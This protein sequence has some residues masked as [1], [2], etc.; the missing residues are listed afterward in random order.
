[1]SR[2]LV[3]EGVD[4]SGKSL[5]AR[6]LVTALQRA[7]HPVRHLR[8][9]G[10]TPVGEALRALLL[11]PET[12][13]LSPLCEMLLFSAA[14]AE[15]VDRA[16]RPELA[17]GIVVVAERSYLSTLVYQALAP[18]QD[19]APLALVQQVTSAVLGDRRPDRIFV[20]DLPADVARARR[21]NRAADRFE[22]R[23]G[24][25]LERV[26]AAFHDSARLDPRVELV[27]ARGT[28]EAVHQRILGSAGACLAERHG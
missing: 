6:L 27:D 19:A 22:A 17:A 26:C 2:W 16:V 28:I 5:Q 23:D 21:R 15:F 18:L 9:P 13:P 1:V 24:D 10:S 12:G 8:E 4:G 7:G 20:L 3:L 11:A 14:R 25:Y